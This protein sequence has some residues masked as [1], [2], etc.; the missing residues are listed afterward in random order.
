MKFGRTRPDFLSFFFPS[1]TD[2]SRGSRT[3]CID[4]CI[5]RAYTFP[6]GAIRADAGPQANWSSFPSEVQPAAVPRER[7]SAPPEAS[8]HRAVRQCSLHPC[9]GSG[10]C[11]EECFRRNPPPQRVGGVKLLLRREGQRTARHLARNAIIVLLPLLRR[12]LDVIEPTWRK[13]H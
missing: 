13:L 5:G 1:P 3:T 11:L 7:G 8:Q 6:A 12:R 9:K 4:S 2:L 10:D